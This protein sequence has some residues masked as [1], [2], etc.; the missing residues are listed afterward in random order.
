MYCYPPFPVKPGTISYCANIDSPIPHKLLF[1]TIKITYEN[2]Q[3]DDIIGAK[4]NIKLSDGKTVTLRRGDIDDGDETKKS[5]NNCC[6]MVMLC[7]GKKVSVKMFDNRM[8]L[9]GIPDKKYEYA[10]HA[11]NVILNSIREAIENLRILRD[12]YE[13]HDADI[14]DTVHDE[15]PTPFVDAILHDGYIDGEVHANDWLE[16][17]NKQSNIVIGTQIIDTEIGIDMLHYNYHIPFSIGQSSLPTLQSIFSALKCWSVNINN[18]K[19]TT[20]KLIYEDNDVKI[21]FSISTSTGSVQQIG[22]CDKNHHQKCWRIFMDIMMCNYEKL[23]YS[24]ITT[25]I[26]YNPQY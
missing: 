4:V 5:M 19:S 7:K 26:V 16:N 3:D 13:I 9:C 12:L 1:R 17:I 20:V 21:T 11:K 6:T 23:Q 10:C 14:Y 15:I 25:T 22:S 2:P 18:A 24:P 8:Q